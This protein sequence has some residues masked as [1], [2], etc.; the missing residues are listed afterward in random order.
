[1]RELG[2]PAGVDDPV[3]ISGFLPIVNECAFA[4][5]ENGEERHCTATSTTRQ[6]RWQCRRGN[7]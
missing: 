3:L 4:I 5:G 6:A 2:L 7:E 1:V